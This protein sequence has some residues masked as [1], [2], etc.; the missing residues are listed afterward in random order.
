[1]N[2]TSSQTRGQIGDIVR[3]MKLSFG[4]ALFL[5][6]IKSF[7]YYRTHSVA[8][9]SDTV[10]SFIHLLAIGFG[11][12]S[13][14]LSFKPADADHTYGHDRIAF[15]SAGVEG[16]LILVGGIYTLYSACIQFFV[17]AP[18]EHQ[19]EGC[20]IFVIAGLLNGL[21]SLYLKKKAKQY[22]MVA[23]EANAKHLAADGLTSLGVAFS[24]VFS[25]WVPFHL[26]ALIALLIGAHILWTGKKLLLKALKG[27]MDAV[28]PQL[29][30]QIR[31]F[32]ERATLTYGIQYH[33]LRHRNSGLRLLV[34]VHLLFPATYSL[35]SAHEVATELEKKM[36]STFPLP[37]ELTTHL[38]PVEGHDEFHSKILGRKG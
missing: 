36:E 2:S 25:L 15:F 24:L 8:I 21:L 32:F 6:F 38:E 29:D 5:F 14:Y 23:L 12:Y 37:M 35:V 22:P 27:L 1:M 10:E 3:A 13:T 18:L 17:K 26:D 11:V 7:A 33:G 20:L 28:D 31:H 4:L 30:R 16:G 9:L 34:E 19:E